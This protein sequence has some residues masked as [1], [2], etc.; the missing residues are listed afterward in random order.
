MNTINIDSN[1]FNELII[2]VDG[3][4]AGYESSPINVDLTEGQDIKIDVVGSEGSDGG[5]TDEAI[6]ALG[7]VLSEALGGI[8]DVL[9]TI[10]EKLEIQT[11]KISQF[12]DN[13]NNKIQKVSDERNEQ[14][15]QFEENLNNQLQ[16]FEE[17]LNDQVQQFEENLT[18]KIQKTSDENNKQLEQFETNLNEK[19][20]NV[21]D[22][23]NKQLQQF[24]DNLV[25]ILEE[26]L[27][28]IADMIEGDAKILF[29]DIS[30]RLFTNFDF[31]H[32]DKSANQVAQ[33]TVEAAATFVKKLNTALE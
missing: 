1:E 26:K 11:D 25:A 18:I 7:E 9:N 29:K 4:E 28:L 2:E 8:T 30:K 22:E 6:A 24:E 17:N 15:Q 13:L 14:L 16:Q 5:A 32:S 31:E 10:G 27:Q 33:E 21:S 19:I 23:R 20:Q 3:G 12:D